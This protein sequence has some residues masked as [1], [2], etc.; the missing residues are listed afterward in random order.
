M[1]STVFSELDFIKQ[2]ILFSDK[3]SLKEVEKMEADYERD[4]INSR[5]TTK[6][7][8]NRYLKTSDKIIESQPTEDESPSSPMKKAKE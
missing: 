7:R 5:F 8:L 1:I 6:S 4:L 3:C 2:L